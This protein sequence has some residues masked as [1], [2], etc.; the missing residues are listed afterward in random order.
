[1]HKIIIWFGSWKRVDLCCCCSFWIFKRIFV[2]VAN[3]QPPHHP[4]P[5]GDKVRKTGLNPIRTYSNKHLPLTLVC[6][7]L[8]KSLVLKARR[9]LH[10]FTSNLT[11]VYVY[12]MHIQLFCYLLNP[13]NLSIYP[14]R[15]Q[16]YYQSILINSIQWLSS[17]SIIWIHHILLR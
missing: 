12:S 4:T 8:R 14:F 16:R 1:V 6:Q 11:V 17:V 10:S 15:S 3:K 2:E 13:T 5:R 7:S 9:K